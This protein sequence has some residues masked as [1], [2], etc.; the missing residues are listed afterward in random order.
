MKINKFRI[1]GFPR[2]GTTLLSSIL[3]S[4]KDS[5]CLDISVEVYASSSTDP[6]IKNRFCTM[7]EA[8]FTHYGIIHPDFRKCN[9]IFEIKTK[10]YEFISDH[11]KVLNIGTKTTKDNLDNLAD[12]VYENTKIILMKRKTDE[13]L[14]S[15]YNKFD[16]PLIQITKTYKNYLKNINYFNISQE[17]K[18]NIYIMDF[19]NLVNNTDHELKKISK[20][21][22]FEISVPDKMYYSFLKNK[23]E[24]K[25]NSSF[26]DINNKIDKKVTHRNIDPN[27]KLMA[28]HIDKPTLFNYPLKILTNDLLQRIKKKFV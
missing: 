16:L 24:W 3:N 8:I 13:I 23:V 19:E 21:L 22:N 28:S 18:K 12:S 7:L 27:I 9:S 20:F 10:F 25:N 17:L 2:S 4:Q 26:G 11:Y 5:C 14:Y 15:W 6:K 1:S